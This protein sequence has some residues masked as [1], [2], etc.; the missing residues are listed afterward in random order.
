VCIFSKYHFSLETSFINFNHEYLFVFL[1]G[2]KTLFSIFKPVRHLS[3]NQLHKRIKRPELLVSLYKLWFS[4]YLEEAVFFFFMSIL[5]SLPRK[6]SHQGPGY[7]GTAS[8]VA[9]RRPAGPGRAAALTGQR[10]RTDRVDYYAGYRTMG[11]SIKLLLTVL[12]FSPI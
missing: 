12:S 8:G 7:C 5:T 1:A 11:P 2:V 4:S 3:L 9:G 6:A 10:P